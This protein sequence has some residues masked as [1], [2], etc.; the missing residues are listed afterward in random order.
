MDEIVYVHCHQDTETGGTVI[1][2]GQDG[3]QRPPILFPKG[4]H[5]LAFLSTLETGLLPR[6]RL[7]PPLWSQRSGCA[8]TRKKRPMPV[9]A[10]TEEV[11]R[12]YVFRVI[13]NADKD[14]CK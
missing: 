1:L 6:G 14:I 11:S 12:D 5:L 2:V 13:D 10:E 8:Q 4:G 7:D 3:V 9:L